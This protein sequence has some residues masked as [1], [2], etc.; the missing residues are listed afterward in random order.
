MAQLVVERH[1]VVGVDH[2]VVVVIGVTGIALAVRV[3]VGAVVVG[4]EHGAG[5]ALV[6]AVG[7]GVV[8]QLVV[9]RHRVVGVDHA[10]VVVIGVTGIALAVRVGVGAV[11]VGGEHGAGGALVAAVGVGVVAQLVVERHRV[12]GVAHA[13]V[14]VIGVTGIALAVAIAVEAIGVRLV[15]GH[16]AELIDAHR[17]IVTGVRV[18]IAALRWIRRRGVDHRLV[19]VAHAVVVVIGVASVTQAVRVAVGAVVVGGEHGAGGAL[20]AGVV[21]GVV[22]HA[23]V[24][25]HRVVAVGH[26]VAV[27]IDQLGE[28]E[29]VA[30]GQGERARGEVG[31]ACEIDADRLR[32]ARGSAPDHQRG[33]DRD[34]SLGQEGV[35]RESKVDKEVSVVGEV[36]PGADD[37]HVAGAAGVIER[38]RCQ[39]R[40]G[41]VIRLAEPFLCGV[42]AELDVE[43]VGL[44]AE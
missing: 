39:Q 34:A 25:R 11:V 21:V 38:R 37:A 43:I 36:H 27:G 23:A 41:V 19:H 2:A 26:A 6:A 1:R 9:E 31:A 40:L 29:R 15:V 44:A 7:V 30:R 12:V 17:A 8:A 20:V 3:G 10:V 5:G 35:Q 16:R 18:A 28:L 14:V 22:A 32:A 13:V 4:G 33:V 24:V 42:L